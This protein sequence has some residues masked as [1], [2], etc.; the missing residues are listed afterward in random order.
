MYTNH[1]T[2]LLVV[3]AVHPCV[4]PGAGRRRVLARGGVRG[5]LLLRGGSIRVLPIAATSE[6]STEL[7]EELLVLVG[8][9][10]TD[11]VER[12]ELVEVAPALRILEHG[13]GTQELAENVGAI[14]A[15]PEK[16]AVVL[17]VLVAL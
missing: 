14:Q 16:G 2:Y 10:G 17:A 9:L 4:K 13:T 3:A 1:V 6:G 8:R 5:A 11:V 12:E 7:V 15:I